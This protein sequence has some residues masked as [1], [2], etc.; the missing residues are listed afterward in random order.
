MSNSISA[1]PTTAIV[2]VKRRAVTKATNLAASIN[3]EHEACLAAASDALD[4][5]MRCGDLLLEA[6]AA[7]S[8]GEWT[9]WLSK[10]FEGSIRTAQIYMRLANNRAAIETNAQPAAHLSIERVIAIIARPRPKS[11]PTFDANLL[12]YEIVEQFEV[13]RAAFEEWKVEAERRITTTADLR[14]LLAL[15]DD[16]QRVMNGWAEYSLRVQR[17][18]GHYLAESEI[19]VAK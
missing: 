13:A 9:G 8:H 12:P 14:E 11:W 16:A 19:G 10:N 7:C 15:R 1:A 5:A 17:F 6:K 4:H 2:K 3:A 18:I